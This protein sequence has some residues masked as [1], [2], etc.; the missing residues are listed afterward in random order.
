MTWSHSHEST[1][2]DFL[3][4]CNSFSNQQGILC[5]H[6]VYTWVVPL[7]VFDNILI[8]Y[9]KKKKKVTLVIMVNCSDLLRI[10]STR[11]NV[12]FTINLVDTRIVEWLFDDL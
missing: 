12:L 9:Q 4:L 5:I 1:F 6:P 7:C 3:E 11:L 10:C 2:S 8:T